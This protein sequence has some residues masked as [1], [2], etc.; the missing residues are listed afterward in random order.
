[1]GD[2]RV[3]E[4]GQA[5]DRCSQQAAR[6]AELKAVEGEVGRRWLGLVEI[7]YNWG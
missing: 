3:E 1:M 5:M 7:D 2:G 6:G 4:V